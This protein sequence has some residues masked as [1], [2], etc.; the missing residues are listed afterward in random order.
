VR[1]LIAR[2]PFLRRLALWPFV[3]APE[4]LSPADAELLLQGAGA[5]GVMPTAHAIARA[6]GWEHL[7]VDLPVALINGDHD[8]IAPLED[9]RAYPGRVDRALVIKCTGHLPM[10]EAPA[11]FLAALNQALES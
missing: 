2:S 5:P 3:R 7:A 8:L 11:T 6:T 4:R 9:L 10:I 1:P